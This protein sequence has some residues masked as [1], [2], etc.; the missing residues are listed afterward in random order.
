MQD[1]DVKLNPGFPWQKQYS[2]KKEGSFHF[3][4]CLKF[5]DKTST[6]VWNIALCGAEN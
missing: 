4:I 5:K 1:V 2:T 3:Q 6:V